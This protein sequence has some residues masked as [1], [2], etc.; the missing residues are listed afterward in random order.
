[1]LFGGGGGGELRASGAFVVDSTWLP[2][3]VGSSRTTQFIFCSSST[4]LFCLELIC[5]MQWY[6]RHLPELSE[7]NVFS[8]LTIFFQKSLTGG[9]G[10]GGPAFPGGICLRWRESYPRWWKSGHSCHKWC[11]AQHALP[12]DNKI[13]SDGLS[14]TVATVKNAHNCLGVRDRVE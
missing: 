10:G 12:S 7:L 13:P 1:M 11:T 3:P 6:K 9:G 8:I 2:V 4:C 5:S 14:S